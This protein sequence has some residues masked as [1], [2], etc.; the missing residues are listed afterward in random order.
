MGRK[1]SKRGSSSSTTEE[2]MAADTDT[3]YNE[4]KDS[5]ECLKTLVTEGLAD[6][7]NDLDKLRQEFKSDI[8]AVNSTVKDLEQSLNFTQSDIDSLKKQF[9]AESEERISEMELLRKKVT[10]LEQSLKEEVERNTNLEQYTRRENLRFKNI[11]ESQDE[12]CEK[13]VHDIIERDLGIDTSGIRFHAVHRVGKRDGSRCRPIIVRFV[14]RMDRDQVWSK[15]GKL[16]K[17]KV[18]TDAYITEDYARAIQ[19][20][21]EILIKAMMKARNEHNLPEAKVKGRFLY[22]NNERFNFENVPEY[23]K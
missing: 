16:K 6:I 10:A 14:C 22:I 20:E 11:K 3:L 1:R 17:S 5:I 7:R 12:D 21:R 15:R 13:V 23:L 2:G 18:H 4:L 19:K 8:K 9:K